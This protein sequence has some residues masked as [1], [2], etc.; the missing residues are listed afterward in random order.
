M[1]G[2]AGCGGGLDT[3]TWILVLSTA[4]RLV[5]VFPLGCSLPCAFVGL[6]AHNNEM[7]RYRTPLS[8]TVVK[9]VG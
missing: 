7:A 1:K 2:G 4:G 5:C 6:F 8:H 3:G 9:G